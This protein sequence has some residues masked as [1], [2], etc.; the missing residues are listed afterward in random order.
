[1]SDSEPQ[2]AS[3]WTSDDEPR[4]VDFINDLCDALWPEVGTRPDMAIPE[5][6]TA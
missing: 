4:S 5:G 1:M 2:F 6:V 3:R